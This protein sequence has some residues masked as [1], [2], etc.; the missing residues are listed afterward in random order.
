VSCFACTAL[1]GEN[2]V[3]DLRHSS[4]P[5]SRAIKSDSAMTRE[6]LLRPE[7]KPNQDI[8]EPLIAAQEAEPSDL[9]P[10]HVTRV[11]LVLAEVATTAGVGVRPPVLPLR[12]VAHSQRSLMQQASSRPRPGRAREEPDGWC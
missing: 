1:P 11:P 7:G 2:S 5:R 10:F 6:T 12:A 4:N 3:G 8:S 9:G